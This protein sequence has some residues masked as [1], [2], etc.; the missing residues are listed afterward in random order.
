MIIYLRQ[1]VY[2]LYSIFYGNVGKWYSMEVAKGGCKILGVQ[3]DQT[4]FNYPFFYK[5]GEKGQ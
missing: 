1:R 2:F 3:F 4:P 5:Y